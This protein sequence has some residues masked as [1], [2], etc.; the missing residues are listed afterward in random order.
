MRVH[1][2]K[3]DGDDPLFAESLRALASPLE[4]V[5][6]D[7]AATL[8]VVRRSGDKAV[9]KLTENFDHVALMPEKLRVDP[10]ELNRA[11]DELDQDVLAAL[12]ACAE[13]V[14]AV[15]EAQLPEAPEVVELPQGH[16]V[17]VREVAVGSA[18]IYA[19]GGRA[20]YPSSA[21]MCCIP[22]AVAGVE[23]IAVASPPDPDGRLNPAVLAACA[24]AGVDEVYAMGGAQA[25]AA[26][27]FGTRTVAPVDVIAGPGNRYVQEAKR[28]VA[29]RVGIDLLAGPSEL[30][31][32]LDGSAD[33]DL[34]ALDLCAQAEHGDDGLLVAAAAEPSV[35]DDLGARV[36]A[37]ATERESV[38]DPPLALVQV[39]DQGSALALADLLAPEHLQLMFEGAEQ[40]ASWVRTAGCVFVGDAGATAFGDYATGSNH[41]LPTG[42]AGRYSGPLGPRTFLR[43][44]S[45]VTISAKA[46]AALAP[47]VDA[48]AR[49]EGFPVHAES[50]RAR[51]KSKRMEGA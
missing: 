44:Q 18:G 23:R 4:D 20:A 41:V 17:T 42:G 21:L 37:L 36:S 35:L 39:A 2:L 34:V 49:A 45:Q 5:A 46:A 30:M 25:I 50:A 43:S 3:W 31:I 47:H 32:V 19:P 1:R 9:L 16:T 22:A 8:L 13:N 6:A 28:Q 15:A 11:A 48:L 12:A 51:S 38:L 10:Q 26:F 14:R 33:L 24:I 40:R 27:A 29:G 7:V